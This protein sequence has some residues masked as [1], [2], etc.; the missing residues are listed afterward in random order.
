MP[1]AFLQFRFQG[2]GLE[3]GEGQGWGQ[4]KA[5]EPKLKKYS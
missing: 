2:Q 3:G 5:M 4:A 1:W